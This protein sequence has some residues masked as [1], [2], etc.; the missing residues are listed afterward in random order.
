MNKQDK[1][2]GDALSFDD[3]LLVPGYSKFYRETLTFPLLSARS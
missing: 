1:F 3:V 2:L